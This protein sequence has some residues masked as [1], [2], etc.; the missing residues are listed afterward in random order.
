MDRTHRRNLRGKGWIAREV[1][2][3]HDY[4]AGFIPECLFASVNVKFT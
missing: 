2:H 1:T 4:M 3:K